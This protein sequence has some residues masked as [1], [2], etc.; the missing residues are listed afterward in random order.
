MSDNLVAI[1]R[2]RGKV[3]VMGTIEDTLELINL[4]RVNHCVFYKDTKAIRGMIF[5]GK[6]Y[7][8]W[9]ESTKESI[10]RVLMKRGRLV[11]DKRITDKWLKEN[12]LDISKL[13]ELFINNPKDVYKLGVKPVFRLTPPSKGFERKGVKTSYSV[14]G[15]LGDRK[16]KIN[17]LLLKM[18]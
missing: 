3:K 2:I 1:I 17:D 10:E 7:I 18:I 5:K 9:G 13:A 11:G 12:K 6:D 8:T 15:A 4:N 14:G 16:E